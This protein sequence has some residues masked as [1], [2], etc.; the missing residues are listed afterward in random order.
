MWYLFIKP[1][2][3]IMN[4]K[5]ALIIFPVCLSI[6]LLAGNLPRLIK[7]H[8]S[9]PHPII[10]AIEESSSEDSKIS[11]DDVGL[12]NSRIDFTRDK[13]YLS[14][15]PKRVYHSKFK[16]VNIVARPPPTVIC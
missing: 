9:K 6:I 8:H 16:L 15:E 3:T 1:N 11:V 2:G 10:K 5:L 7:H 12:G 4:K 13:Y 14:F